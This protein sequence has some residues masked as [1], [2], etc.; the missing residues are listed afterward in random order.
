MTRLG[1]RAAGLAVVAIVATSAAAL[2]AQQKLLTLDDL[3]DPAKK[4]NFGAPSVPGGGY[5]WLNDKEYLRVKDA[6][7][8]QGPGF[9]IVRVD[10]LTGTETPLFD[11]ARLVAALS[12]V[13]GLSADDAA[14]LSRQRTYAMNPARTALVV[15]A[16]NDL[17]LWQLGAE[18]VVRLT[19]S[20]AAEEEVTF[21]PDGRLLAFVR[22]HNLYVVDLDGRERQLTV[23]GHAQRLN[24]KLDWVYQEEIYGR[25]THRAYWFSPDSSRLAF[26]QLDEAPVPEFTVVD[27][28]P[29]RQGVET[30]DYPKAGDPNPT[31]KLG[32]VRA[33]GGD[34][35]WIDTSKYGAAEHLI[36]N[37]D[38]APDSKD[39]V[40]Q[41]QDREQTWLDLNLG[42][43][44]KGTTTTLFRETTKAW[45]S[46]NGPPAWLKDG[47]F[48]WFSERDG[49]QHLYRYKR[50]GSL[51]GRI[52]S[53]KWEVRTL[54]GVDEAAGFVYFAGTERSHI[55]G[56]VY[57]AKLDGSGLIRLSERAG[58]NSASFNPG[59]THY[60]GTWSNVSTPPQVRL[61]KADGAEVRVVD[62]NEVPT[63]KDYRLSTPEFLQVTTK[64]GFTLEAMLIKPVDF[65]PSRKYPV[66]QSTYAGPHAPSVRNSWGGT[67]Q[68]YHQ[69]LAQRGIAVWV[70]DNR[71]ASGKGAESAWVAYKRLGE[72]E[73]ADIEECLGFLKQQPWVDASRIGIN[74]WSYGGF[75]TSYALTHSTSFAMGIAGGSVTDWRDYDSIYTERYMLMPQNNPDGYARTAP[76]AA[77]KNLHGQLF[78]I[79]GT[80]D[81]NV[82]MQN[83]IQFAYDLQKAGKPFELMLYP[84]SRHGVTD[85]QLV[86][87]M[88]ERML[89]FT[90]RTLKPEPG[91]AG[92]K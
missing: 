11:Q 14:R 50:D 91:P 80:M 43:A 54:Y 69:L 42:E 72:T 35:Q 71:S 45:V 85:P 39:V 65:D 15:N 66:F 33:A 18:R 73:L 38:W 26:L 70:C 81:D 86:K 17:F 3:Y 37:V 1:F 68:L 13:P 89:E 12:A 25:G 56:D 52:T 22:A 24:G 74:G 75:M 51:V 30:T 8:P 23:D 16:S 5:T 88:R 29:Y 64:D 59:F 78:L 20:A 36:V 34:V 60:V 40:Y 49:W 27:H 57:R 21:S 2:H 53:G 90:L 83:T 10:A 62:R 63:L 76:R 28:I 67:G 79:H 41:V 82:H 92:T 48:L 19:W 4:V 77:A 9:A 58:T 84:K 31:V 55:G 7:T 47:S 61:H 44:G 6:R 46:E 32:V 87:H